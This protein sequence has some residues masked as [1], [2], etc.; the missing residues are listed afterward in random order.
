MTDKSSLTSVVLAL[1]I[2]L[3]AGCDDRPAR[4]SL[5][6]HNNDEL[7]DTNWDEQGERAQPLD[8]G[9]DWDAP[10]ARAR[11]GRTNLQLDPKRDVFWTVVL[12]TFTG[13][14]HQQSAATM[15][16]SCASIDP[17]LA[18]ARIHTTSKGSMVVFGIFDRPESTE[19]Q[20]ALEFIKS[21]E[22]RDRKVFPM[23]L[24]TKIN[25]RHARREFKPNELLG[26]RLQYPDVNPLYTLQVA[27]WGDFGSGELSLDEI[28]RRAEDEV[29]RLRSQ[30]HEAFFHHNPDRRLSVITV[31]LF[32]R[33][34]IDA[35]SGLVSPEVEALMEK[36]PAQLA[37]GEPLLEYIDPNR[38]GLGTRPV[39]PTLVLVPEL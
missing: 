15:I 23:A 28:Q 4:S 5:R 30:G 25:V 39:R 14:G 35:A 32:G 22:L 16:R 20:D 7:L 10:A 18:S 11:D 2:I 38:P 36:F 31:G 1:C 37:N 34:A 26:V 8:L 13:P 17:A 21:I 24:L 12:R 27:E 9:Q 29:R 3:I 33:S 6:G 19:A